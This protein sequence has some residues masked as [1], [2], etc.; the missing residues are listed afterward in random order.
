MRLGDDRAAKVRRRL[1]FASGVASIPPGQTANVRLRL[2]KAGRQIVRTSERRK[3]RGDADANS[4]ETV[5]STR[6][7]IRLP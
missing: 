4:V 5:S 7:R 6:I 1:L 3:L 2:R